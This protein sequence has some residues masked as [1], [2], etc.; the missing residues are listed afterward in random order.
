MQNNLIVKINKKIKQEE[1]R[2]NDDC[3]IL[4]TI[5]NCHFF[6]IQNT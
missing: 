2:K 5:V 4:S 3:E 6:N 1:E